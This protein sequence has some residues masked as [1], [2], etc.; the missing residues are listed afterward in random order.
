VLS[1]LQDNSNL[2]IVLPILIPFSR[3]LFYLLKEKE[4]KIKEYMKIMGLQETAYYLSWITHYFGIFTVIGIGCTIFLKMS[5][6]SNSNVFL[7]FAWLFFSYILHMSRAVFLS[8]FFSKTKYGVT[9]GIVLY[10]IEEIILGN[11]I[12]DPTKTTVMAHLLASF[13]PS[14]LMHRSGYTIVAFEIMERGIVPNT[15]NE[16]Y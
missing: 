6:M 12:P 5:A 1:L 16:E 7:I 13:S 15:L 8:S 2:F 11:I 3:F 9:L 4:Y 10:F 14:Y